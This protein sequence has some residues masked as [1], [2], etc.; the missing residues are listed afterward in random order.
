MHFFGFGCE[1]MGGAQWVVWQNKYELSIFS[2]GNLDGQTDRQTDRLI[3][4]Y[5]LWNSV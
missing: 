1:P 5:E 4:R 3:Y 2:M